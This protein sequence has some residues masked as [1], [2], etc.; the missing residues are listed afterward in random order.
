MAT[1]KLKQ[2][3]F[4]ILAVAFSLNCY[5]QKTYITG[6]SAGDNKLKAFEKKMDALEASMEEFKRS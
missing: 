6:T 1:I 4:G 5:S 2:L 3:I